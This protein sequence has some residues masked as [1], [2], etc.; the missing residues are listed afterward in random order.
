MAQ[1]HAAWWI[2]RTG[3]FNNLHL[4]T[5]YWAK[6]L[7][8]LPGAWCFHSLKSEAKKK[9]TYNGG[10]KSSA[11]TIVCERTGLTIIIVK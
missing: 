11:G 10:S 3:G 7:Q 5:H 8:R 9:I 1:V 2:R 6:A 4:L